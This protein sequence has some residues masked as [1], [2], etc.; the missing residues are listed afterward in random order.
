MKM[1]ILDLSRLP[2][3]MVTKFPENMEETKTWIEEIDYVIGLGTGYV[4]YYPG[5]KANIESRQDLLLA[6]KLLTLWLK[7]GKER[8]RQ[9]FK[10]IIAA[11]ADEEHQ[12]HLEKLAPTLS[13]IYG[14]PLYVAKSDKDV[15][16]ALSVFEKLFFA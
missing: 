1:K 12:L 10:G 14:V 6:R 13:S 2:L 16:Q 3:V 4:L 9:S 7:R 5:V 11:A 8:F 15:K